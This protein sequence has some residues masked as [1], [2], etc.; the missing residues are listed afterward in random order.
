MSEVIHHGRIDPEAAQKI[1]A[2]ILNDGDQ[3]I[4]Q[5]FDSYG[6]PRY[7]CRYCKGGTLLPCVYE[8]AKD[9]VVPTLLIEGEN[10]E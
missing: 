5:G 10:H 4:R 9:S 6:D 8:L 2:K 1:V 7:L 3:Y